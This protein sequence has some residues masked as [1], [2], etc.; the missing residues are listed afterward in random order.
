MKLR[1]LNLQQKQNQSFKRY[2]DRIKSL[3]MN[4]QQKIDLLFCYEELELKTF[5]R[6]YSIQLDKMLGSDDSLF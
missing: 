1:R 4:K 6:P 3:A 5:I 2:V